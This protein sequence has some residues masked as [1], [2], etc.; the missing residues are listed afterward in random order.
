MIFSNQNKNSSETKS[1][2]WKEMKAFEQAL[3]SFRNVFE[4]KTLKWFTDNQN[5]VKIVKSGSM[6]Y[7]LLYKLLNV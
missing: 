1:L 3:L 5:C 7:Q 2:T 6:K 4:G